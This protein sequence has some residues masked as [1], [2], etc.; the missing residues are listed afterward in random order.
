M[1]NER[2][3]PRSRLYRNGL[4]LLSLMS[5][6]AL[7]HQLASGDSYLLVID[8]E[9]PCEERTVFTLLRSKLRVLASYGVG[10]LYSSYLLTDLDT[11]G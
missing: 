8:V 2:W 7:L 11:V 5:G 4:P 3:P 10:G 6:Y 9:C 1:C